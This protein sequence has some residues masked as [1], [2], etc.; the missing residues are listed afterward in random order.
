[1]KRGG[2]VV[3][4]GLCVCVCVCVVEST[5]KA[6]VAL[7]GTMRCAGLIEWATRDV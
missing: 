1:V 2:G 3:R 5:W 7:G 4:L 6:H